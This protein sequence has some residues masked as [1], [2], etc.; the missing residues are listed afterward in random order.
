MAKSKYEVISPVTYGEI[1]E[2][3]VKESRFGIGDIA[4]FSD[5]IAGPLLGCKAIRPVENA[6][7]AAD[8]KPE[9][10]GK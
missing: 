2:G 4:A 6:A 8:G 7:K 3:A 10:P 9:D 1:V 5:E